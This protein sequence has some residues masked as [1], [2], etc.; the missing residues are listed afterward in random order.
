MQITESKIIRL[1][2][3]QYKS[4]LLECINE[5]DTVDSR[6]NMVLGKDLKVRHKKSQYEYTVDDV[7]E[8]PESGD[9]QIALRLP[10]EPRV[11]PASEPDR[12]ISDIAPD[13]MAILGEDDL[14]SS[15]S[16]LGSLALAQKQEIPIPPTDDGE[17]EIIFTIDQEEFEKEYEV[18]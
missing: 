5:S 9:I 15:E 16:G 11:E 12:V 6:G 7:I 18:K 4:R 13:E 2:R 14:L 17:E 10:D 3:G 8:D 1:L